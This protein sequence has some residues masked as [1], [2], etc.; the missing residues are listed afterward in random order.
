MPTEWVWE[1]KET[2]EQITDKEF[3]RL[4]NEVETFEEFLALLDKYILVITKLDR[5]E[6]S[7]VTTPANK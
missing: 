1:D 3:K 7:F 2:E 6:Y 5:L 4:M